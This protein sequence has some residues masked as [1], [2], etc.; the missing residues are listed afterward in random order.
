ML[1]LVVMHGSNASYGVFLTQFEEQFKWSRAAISGAGSLAF[2]VMGLFATV[3]GRLTDR[4]GPRLTMLLSA[5]FMGA[6]FLLIAQ[7]NQLWQLY[8]AYGIVAG[9][10]NSSGDVSLLPTVARW[11]VRRRSLM[12][13]LVK[14]GTGIGMFVVPLLATW[15]ILTYNWRVAYVVLAVLI[16]L[17]VIGFSRLIKRDP[18]EMGLEAHGADDG[19]SGRALDLGANLTLRETLRTWQFWTMC[20]A[21]FLV[22][23]I[24]QSVMVHTA[25]HAIDTGLT[26][27]RAAGIVSIIGAAS[28]VG[29]LSIGA[30]GDRITV[31]RA[32]AICFGILLA[33]I[34]WLQF[35]S[36]PWM[37]YPFAVVYGFAHGGAFAVTSPLMAEMFGIK[38]HASNLGMLFFIGQIGGAI[39]PI[40]TGRIFDVTQS[41]QIAFFILV[42][43]SAAAVALMSVVR[44]V[45]RPA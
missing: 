26:T 41:Y 4:Y 30:L 9:I 40:V 3:G 32:V 6:G 37:L 14:V 35:A 25:A 33:A 18:S 7:I 24:T 31:R 22:W 15:L 44:P 1:T 8:L 27:T 5:C 23:Y 39:G 10:G 16:L 17:M 29:R 42:G 21:Y 11:F 12:S 34:I 19:H 38:A 2:F 28:I 36:S 20:S 45:R 43:A 13:S